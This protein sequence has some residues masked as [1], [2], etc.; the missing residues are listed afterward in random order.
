MKLKDTIKKIPTPYKTETL[1]NYIPYKHPRSRLYYKLTTERTTQLLKSTNDLEIFSSKA[2]QVATEMKIKPQFT[3][4][5][6]SYKFVW[7]CHYY[8]SLLGLELA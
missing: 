2:I 4:S 3:S 6:D 5:D 7:F 1:I 8:V